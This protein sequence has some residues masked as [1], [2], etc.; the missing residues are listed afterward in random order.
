MV[1]PARGRGNPTLAD[2]R[3]VYDLSSR[4]VKVGF[5]KTIS[6]IYLISIFIALLALL[7]VLPM[8]NL[9]MPTK[10]E[11]PGGQ[12]PKRGIASPEG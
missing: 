11:G 12:N 6:R 3:K 2:A 7:A 9:K 10:G 4:A 1:A 8:P 5:A